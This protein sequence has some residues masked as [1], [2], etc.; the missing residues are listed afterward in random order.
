MSLSL[1]YSSISSFVDRIRFGL[2]SRWVRYSSESLAPPRVV[3]YGLFL[4]KGLLSRTEP[5]LEDL[6]SFSYCESVSRATAI[7]PF[8]FFDLFSSKLIMSDAASLPRFFVEPLP[9]LSP[10]VE[11]ELLFDNEDR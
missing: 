4:L 5:Y 6:E 8:F 10:V 11:Y 7:T 1:G 9:R 3:C 2:S